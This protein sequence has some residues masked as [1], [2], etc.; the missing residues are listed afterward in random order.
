MARREDKPL[1]SIA[2]EE[3]PGRLAALRGWNR[4]L[5]AFALGLLLAAAL[6][7][8]YILPTALIAF[9]GLAW[10][11]DGAST[12][13]CA[14]MDGW[15][16]GTG[17]FLGGFYWITNALLVDSA[18]YG[19]MVPFAL[20]AIA[21]GFGL[22]PAMVALVAHMAPAGQTRAV[23]FALAWIAV[24][25][26]RS[27]IL[28]GFP[29]NMVGTALGLSDALLQP[30]A[31]GGPWL[32]TGLV[33]LGA[34]FPSCLARGGRLPRMRALAGIG[35]SAVLIAALWGAGSLRLAAH[36][37][38]Y[39][40]G[41][42][43]RLV[44]PAI[45]QAD[46]WRSNLID[47]HFAMHIALSLSQPASEQPYVIIWPEASIPHQLLRQ[48]ATLAELRVIVPED[49]AILTGAVRAAPD[50]DG[51][52]RPW[53][54]LLVIDEAGIAQTYDKHHLVPFGEYMPLRGILPIDKLTPGAVDFAAGPGPV[55]INQGN[56][57]GFGPLVCYEVIF[58]AEIIAEHGR[59]SWLLNVTNDGWYGVSTGP[60]QH[61]LTARLR[62]VEQG[63]PMVR[64]ANTG[65]SGFIDPLGRVLSSLPFNHRGVLDGVLPQPLPTLTPY[66]RWGDW[67]LLL[68]LVPGLVFLA[69]TL[70][71][72]RR[73][74]DGGSGSATRRC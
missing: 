53:N 11:L 61:F 21:L 60:Y 44:Q 69:W 62:A 9:T 46:K 16:F 49:G 58:P 30:A 22:F 12:Y 34:L 65:I 73:V 74:G 66:A 4:A 19:W 71:R 14:W 23:L 8:I 55:V 27:W 35:A 42:V 50:T 57:P 37:T 31:L 67:T 40:Q 38:T 48:P 72:S 28:T 2:P 6:P 13:R 10:M 15:L 25:W 68:V 47:S 1:R 43:L 7:P 51:T 59:P 56:L 39:Q 54:S 52:L 29:W 20:A 18:Q 70:Q 41:V 63:L 5:S 26:L 45:P 24:E 64:A 33:L 17:F 3:L 32:L 36:P